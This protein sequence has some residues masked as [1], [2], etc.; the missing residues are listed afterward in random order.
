MVLI[1]PSAAQLIGSFVEWEFVGQDECYKIS[2]IAATDNIG[3]ANA[4]EAVT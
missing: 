1:V 4:E 3:T 2:K